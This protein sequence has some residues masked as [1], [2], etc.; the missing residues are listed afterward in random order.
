MRAHRRKVEAD[1]QPITANV[2]TCAHEARK[3][4][5]NQQ[6]TTNYIELPSRKVSSLISNDVFNIETPVN[7]AIRI[8]I[9]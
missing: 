4:S 8:N 1:T 9:N 2:I 5:E 3:K 6:R 7:G